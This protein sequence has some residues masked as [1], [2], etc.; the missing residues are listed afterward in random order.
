MR[1]VKISWLM[2]QNQG[3]LLDVFPK[4]KFEKVK[5]ERNRD[6]YVVVRS[7]VNYSAIALAYSC[8]VIVL[9]AGSVGSH[10]LLG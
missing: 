2:R 5:S 1:I 7:T 8:V 10:N 4:S 3:L 6:I 9:F